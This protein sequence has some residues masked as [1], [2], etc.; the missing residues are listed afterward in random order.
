MA[1]KDSRRQKLVDAYLWHLKRNKLMYVESEPL[2]SS[3]DLS[4]KMQISKAAKIYK[5][6]VPEG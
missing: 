3:P 6:K 1:V 5:H 2:S 4:M